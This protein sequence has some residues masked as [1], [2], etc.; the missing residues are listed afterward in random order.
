MSMPP[1]PTSPKPTASSTTLPPSPSS[2]ASVPSGSGRPAN[3]V[4]P[5]PPH[6]APFSFPVAQNGRKLVPIVPERSPQRPF[7][8]TDNLCG[9][10]SLTTMN[11]PSIRAT[12]AKRNARGIFPA[13]RK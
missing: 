6:F 7:P 2:M 4:H 11:T 8:Q 9:E 12:I 3:A 5:A 1:S 10:R 13:V